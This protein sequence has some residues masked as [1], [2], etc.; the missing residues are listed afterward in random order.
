M[1]CLENKSYQKKLGDPW[2]LSL[3]KRRLRKDLV[4]RY[5]YLKGGCSEVHVGLFCQ[6]TS[7]RTRGND[8]KLF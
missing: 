6:V 5:Y 1:K 2:L 7:N 8:L 4:A 3:E